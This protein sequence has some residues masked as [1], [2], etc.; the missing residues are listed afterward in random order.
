ML[1]YTWKYHDKNIS[2]K[3]VRKSEEGTASIG[4]GNLLGKNGKPIYGFSSLEVVSASDDAIVLKL[5]GIEKTLVLGGTV[6]F[7]NQYY[8]SA[9]DV[10]VYRTED[11]ALTLKWV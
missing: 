3:D 6:E 4:D 1:K 10:G 11:F 8:C 9:E 2:G 7:K 5:K